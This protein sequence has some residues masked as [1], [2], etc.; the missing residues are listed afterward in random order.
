MPSPRVSTHTSLNRLN[1]LPHA[2]CALHAHVR[3]HCLTR[4]RTRADPHPLQDGG[5]CRSVPHPLRRAWED[6]DVSARG[7]CEQGC[8]RR[9]HQQDGA[10]RKGRAPLSLPMHPTVYPLIHTFVAL[11]SCHRSLATVIHP[12]H[13]SPMQTRDDNE[14]PSCDTPTPT[15]CLPKWGGCCSAR[16]LSLPSWCSAASTPLYTTLEPRCPPDHCT[17]VTPR[18]RAAP[19]PPHTHTPQTG[20]AH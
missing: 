14:P 4:T 7:T 19:P 17:P 6:E 13:C 1:H 9:G 15:K 12:I 2:P 8:A 10:D 3:A 20:S 5:L 16:G 18:S 11:C